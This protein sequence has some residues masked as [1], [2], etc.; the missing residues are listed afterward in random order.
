MVFIL[1][2]VLVINNNNP[3][4]YTGALSLCVLSVPMKHSVSLA[5]VFTCVLEGICSFDSVATTVEYITV[6][7]D[8]FKVWHYPQNWVPSPLFSHLFREPVISQ[9]LKEMTIR[10]GG[11]WK[12]EKFLN[13]AILAQPQLYHQWFISAGTLSFSLCAPIL[14]PSQPLISDFWEWFAIA[15]VWS[16]P[17]YCVWPRTSTNG[18]QSVPLKRLSVCVGNRYL[19]SFCIM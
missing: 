18:A 2:F 5:F 9:T 19:T 14:F 7:L 15:C 10:E 4:V 12:S 1:V 8:S 3:G 16:S 17:G 13:T 6:T 11:V